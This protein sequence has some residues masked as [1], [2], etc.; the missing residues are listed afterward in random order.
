MKKYHLMAPGPTPVP[1]EVLLAMARP[2]IHHRTPE[3]EA[4]FAEVRAGLG[5]L[6]QTTGDVVVLACSGTGVMEAA[7][8]NTLSPGETVAVVVAGKFG[9]RWVEIARAYGLDVVELRAPFGGTV[10]PARVADTLRARP[11]IKAVLAQHSESST[12]VLHDVRGYAEVTRSTDAILIVDAVSSLGIANLPMDAWGVDAVV[13]GSQKGLML[14]PGVAF[15][16]L[17]ERAWAAAK[18]ST[19]PK[20]YFNLA[21]ERKAVVKNEAHF[22]PAVSI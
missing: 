2:M 10:P 12:G 18:T 15:C 14:P 5:W 16:A 1:S 13:A 7:V 8:V 11:G 9:E 22:T 3:Y 19:L 20:Y 6:L 21:E 17:G 4:L